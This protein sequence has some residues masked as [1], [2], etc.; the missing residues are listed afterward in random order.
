MIKNRFPV[1]LGVL[2]L[3]TGL[4]SKALGD[5]SNVLERLMVEAHKQGALIEYRVVK[6]VL[7][8]YRAG[9]PTFGAKEIL[10]LVES[11]KEESTAFSVSLFW[12]NDNKFYKDSARTDRTLIFDGLVA[13]LDDSALDSYSR[14]TCVE[15]LRRCISTDV[16]SVDKWRSERK[17]QGKGVGHGEEPAS[18][19][20]SRRI[21]EKNAKRLVQ[22]LRGELRS[23]PKK[24]KSVPAKSVLS[25]TGR[26][27]RYELIDRQEYQCIL[28]DVVADDTEEERTR[29]HAARV[30]LKVGGSDQAVATFLTEQVDRSRVDATEFFRTVGP[31]LRRN[32]K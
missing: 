32:D 16:L 4:V 18:V 9:L 31:L 1:R 13:M 3:I 15:Y 6:E 10:A 21:A 2:F 24:K 20:E 19:A 22:V 5:Q 29:I 17:A 8:L 11:V 28:S 25:E 27:F 30:L 23:G 14:Q 12:L 26:L 7:E